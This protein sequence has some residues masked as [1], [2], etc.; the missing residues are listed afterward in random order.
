M[1]DDSI[2]KTT[3]NEADDGRLSKVSHD[4]R[5]PLNAVLGMSNMILRATDKG[6]ANLSEIHH[7]AE[8]IKNA[9]E[10]LLLLTSD[11]L[12]I[13]DVRP[14][15]SDTASGNS[16]E[17]VKA[18]GDT[19]KAES[20]KPL[21]Q[22]ANASILVADDNSVNRKVFRNLLRDTGLTIDEATGGY[23]C[24][25]KAHDIRYDMIFLDYMMPDQNGIKTL[26]RIR[27]DGG[28]NAKTPVVALTASTVSETVRKLKEAGFD[29]IISKPIMPG[30]LERLI[31]DTLPKEK[32]TGSIDKLAENNE[33]YDKEEQR[34]DQL[35]AIDIAKL[36]A[37]DKEELDG[38]FRDISSSVPDSFYQYAVKIHSMKTSALMVKA[39]EPWALAKSLEEA[40]ENENADFIGSVH[41]VFTKSW[42]AMGEQLEKD[43]LY[44]VKTKG[45]LDPEYEIILHYLALL[46]KA[47]EELDVESADTLLEM[48]RSYWYPEEL[49]GYISRL[50]A[51]VAGLNAADTGKYVSEIRGIISENYITDRKN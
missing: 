26:N 21:F 31:A 3:D 13:S 9:G 29:A 30:E 27:T 28:K 18:S 33:G 16:D 41:P 51:A 20:Y 19:G 44:S 24:V 45:T 23:E 4:I 50:N 39:Y 38:Y 5:T 25:A 6:D 32:I 46:E 34:S 40:A 8:D 48:I 7:F 2:K 22:A 43:Y 1:S 42:M 11:Y 36:Y 37:G 15:Q 47:V 17:R 12:Y 10:E 14:D 35:V 49:A